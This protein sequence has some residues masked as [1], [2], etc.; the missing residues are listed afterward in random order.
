M[1]WTLV[2]YKLPAEP[3]RHRVAV[4]R[5]LRKVGAVPLQQGTWALP[6]R[7]DFAESLSKVVGLVDAAG[8]EAFVFDAAPRDE[9]TGARLEEAFNADR[10]EEWT[11]FLAECDK[12]DREIDKEIPDAEV[13]RGGIGRGGPEPAAVAALVPGSSPPGRVRGRLATAHGTAPQ[14]VRSS[15]G[16]LR[17]SRVLVWR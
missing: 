9:A 11:E 13:H 2:T 4:W 15:T 10:E 1:E 14:G 6:A 16:G 3:S 5:E 8:G 17:E 12:F 7:R